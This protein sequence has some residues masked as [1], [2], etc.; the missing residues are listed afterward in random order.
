MGRDIPDFDALMALY[1]RDPQQFEAFRRQALREAIDHA[2]SVHRPALDGLLDK[3][4]V[5]REAAATPMDAAIAASR[6]MR[7]SAERLLDAWEDA[8]EEIAGLQAAVL[9]DRMRAHSDA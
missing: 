9:I 7:E 6:M 2:P 8:H 3:I 1:Q 4:E 5:A